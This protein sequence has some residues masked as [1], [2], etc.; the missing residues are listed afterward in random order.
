MKQ[1]MNIKMGKTFFKLVYGGNYETNDISGKKS[2]E[3]FVTGAVRYLYPYPETGNP[4]FDTGGVITI[5]CSI[6]RHLVFN[7]IWLE[8][9][10]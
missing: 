6:N 9:T 10:K 3:Y 1:H 7:R 8:V 2:G 4:A 5:H